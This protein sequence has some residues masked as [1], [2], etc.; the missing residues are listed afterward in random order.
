MDVGVEAGVGVA[1]GAFE[2]GTDGADGD[3]IGGE[4][5]VPDAPPLHAENAASAIMENAMVRYIMSAV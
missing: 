2:D 4:G 1:V 3:T 5:A